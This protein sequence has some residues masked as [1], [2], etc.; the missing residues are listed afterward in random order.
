MHLVSITHTH[1][2]A[3]VLFGLK[4]NLDHLCVC[5]CVCVCV[6]ER[7]ESESVR[8]SEK[9]VL[10]ERDVCVRERCVR[11]KEREMCVRER[12]RAT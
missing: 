12:E 8:A 1:T 6:N 4:P 5:V 10:G 11:E 9:C 2:P 3:E 7:A